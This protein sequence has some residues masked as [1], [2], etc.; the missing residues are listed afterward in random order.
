[1]R[2][3]RIIQAPPRGPFPQAGNY[4]AVQPEPPTDVRKKLEPVDRE[5]ANV[6]AEKGETVAMVKS[7]G[8]LSLYDIGGKRHAQGGTPLNLPEKSF[9]FSDFKT[10]LKIKDPAI[11]S[12]FNKTSK[13]GKRGYTPAEISKQYDINEYLRVLKDPMSTPV[14]ISTAEQ[15]IMNSTIKLG[16]L[17]L[18]Q[19]SMKGF[20][21]GIPEIAYPY[22]YKTG[23]DPA[24]I[25]PV[26][27][28][29]VAEASP[30][31]M[32]QQNMDQEMGMAKWGGN[33]VP[34][35]RFEKPTQVGQP[36]MEM[37]GTP[38]VY[39]R[40]ASYP[41]Y[42][43]KMS[44]GG[45]KTKTT[46]NPPKEKDIEVDYDPDPYVLEVRIANAQKKYPDRN[47]F[48][49]QP[50]GKYKK[51]VGKVIPRI[52]YEGK[53]DFGKLRNSFE[54]LMYTIDND[55]DLQT[56]IYNN[57]LEEL[58]NPK[59]PLTKTQRERLKKKSPQEVINNFKKFQEHVY[60]I[61]GSGKDISSEEWDDA[62][63]K[64]SKYYEIADE[65]GL[66]PLN[67]DEIAMGQAG[68]WGAYAAAAKPK[69]KYLADNFII[70]AHGSSDEK[71]P[72]NPK[73]SKVDAIFGNTTNRQALLS[74]NQFSTLDV[75][76]E[77]DKEDE[78]GTY[79][80][81]PGQYTTSVSNPEWWNQNLV[82]LQGAI[83]DRYSLRKYYPN[84][85]TVDLPEL[86]PAYVSP[87]RG[88]AANAEQANIMGQA[89]GAYSGPQSTSARLSD[90]YAKSARQAADYLSQVHN[91]NIG[92]KNQFE[93]AQADID[94]KETIA[95]TAA[96]KEFYDRNTVLQ[97]QYDN[98]LR[99]AKQEVRKMYNYGTT[100]AQ[101]TAAMNALYPHYQVDPSTGQVYFTR[102]DEMDP[103]SLGANNPLL[104][105]YITAV[106][107]NPD[108]AP[109]DIA[110]FFIKD[111]VSVGN[112][113]ANPMEMYQMMMGYGQD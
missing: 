93:M 108:I 98:S 8:L 105:S 68:F 62:G 51:V 63:K 34:L 107:E 102:G 104:Q 28:Q 19:E 65:L 42:L 4:N 82:D 12:Y 85:F 60:T 83:G 47:I 10:K 32:M 90:I 76:E 100:A 77:A 35:T 53:S 13:K 112:Q 57:Y 67:D 64:N 89:L 49:K 33:K 56:E 69:F 16:Q 5:N 48:V 6:E 26:N 37:G 58:K 84:L 59:H 14:Q 9:V 88:L 66:D 92:I 7:G 97:Q 94:A 106:R 3:V 36:F 40:E 73:I 52:K 71:D 72:R 11:L 18:V 80:V 81:E 25:L 101:Q 17:A 23:I 22:L 99:K 15:N 110:K 113:F 75:A 95:N 91:T 2:K 74:R 45:T 31:Q 20:P 70:G 103:A 55:P 54:Q 78:V 27:P 24:T 79:D 109:E 21:D 87:E 1:M 29:E 50:D 43:S 41:V 44:D 96:M 86:S 46:V 38:M 111:K 30:E 61:S 39:D